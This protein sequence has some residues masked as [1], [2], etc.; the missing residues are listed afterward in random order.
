MALKPRYKRRII[1]SVVTIVAAVIVALVIIPPMITLDGMRGKIEHAIETQTGITAQI[2]G[3][4]HFSLLGRATI[5]AHDVVI[6]NGHIDAVMFSIPLTHIFNLADAPL[7]NRII[8]GGAKLEISSLDAP[9]F[10]HAVDIYDSNIIFG[11]KNYEIQRAKFINGKLNGTVRTRDHKYDIEFENDEFIIRNYNNNL[12]ITGQLFSDGTARGHLDIET[13]NVNEWF[14]FSTPRINKKIK[15]SMDFNWDGGS[16]FEFTNIESDKFSGSIKLSSD[17]NRDIRLRATDL[18]YDFS[19]LMNPSRLYTRTIFD[20]DLY[21]KLKMGNQTFNH[22]RLNAIGTHDL[23]QISTIIADDV[24]ITGGTIDANGA[25]DILIN[26]PVD[27]VQTMCLFSG[28]PDKWTCNKFAYGNIAGNIAVDQDSFNAFISADENMPDADKLIRAVR[29]LG[30]RGALHFRFKNI[31]G[32]FDID[33]SKVNSSYTFA[34][35]KNLRW[36]MPTFKY[37]PNFMLDAAGDFTWNGAIMKFTPYNQKWN[38]TVAKNQ[39]YLSGKNFKELLPDVNLQ[40]VNN[41]EYT[42]SGT[43]NDRNI[44]N[45]ELRIAD[46]IFTGTASGRNITLRT[47]TLNIDAFANQY[48]IDNYDELEF[49]GPSPLTVP[50]TLPVNISL[51][52][53]TVIYNGTE[54]KN[55]VYALK[56]NTQILSITDRARGNLLA[57]ISQNDNQYDISAQLNRFVIDG[58]LLSGRMPINIRDSVITADINMKT[59]GIIAHD[60]FYNLTGDIDMIV[61][62]GYLVGLG[63]DDFY[64]GANQIT[65]FNAEYALADALTSGETKIKNMH[66]VGKYDN[67]GFITS[68]PLTLQMRHIDAYGEFDVDSGNM[69]VVLNMVLRGTSPTPAPLRLTIAPDGTRNYS[70]TDIMTNFDSGFMRSFVKTHSQF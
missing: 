9:D 2:T 20:L 49:L 57:T 37:L 8:V 51:S 58:Y 67:S 70:L 25:H 27:G 18:D 35:N 5:V 14:E 11:G 60:I 33:G 38:I 4:V 64:A 23:I 45:L 22:L 46:H 56:P 24:A 26:M 59:H 3:N 32:T 53:D 40:S 47:D 16:G 1:W 69:T 30:T 55:F 39:F 54:Y 13:A 63:F 31:A 43:F 17:G 36:A 61:D 29:R 44:S 6:P 42:I 34:Q 19:F 66:I 65:S 28:T 15:L 21:G 52:A 48:Y 68:R 12:E 7:S 62:G 50:F 41:F 10:V